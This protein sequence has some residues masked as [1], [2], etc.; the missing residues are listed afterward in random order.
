MLNIFRGDAGDHKIY[1]EPQYSAKNNQL[2]FSE[3]NKKESEN[4]MHNLWET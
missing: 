1:H 2:I 4:E 3:K